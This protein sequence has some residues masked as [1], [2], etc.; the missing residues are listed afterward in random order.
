[1]SKIEGGLRT[2]N[3]FAKKTWIGKPLVSVITVV[4]NS[5]TL[6]EKTILSVLE[7][8][9]FNIEFIIIDG[10]SSDKTIEIIKKYNNQI[11]YWMS[12]KDSGLYD[13]MNKG[14]SYATG[15]YVWFI[16]SGDKIYADEVLETIF[17]I[18]GADADIYYGE[19]MMIGSTDEEIG[20]RRLSTPEELSWKSF[21]KGM[22]VSHQSII[23]RKSIAPL[24]E[25]QYRFSA[26]FDWVLKC[27]KKAKNV[28]NTKMVL[29]K[30]LDGGLT[31]KNIV[32]GLKERFRIM[33]KHYGYFSTFFNHL[34]L[35]WNFI[36]YVK[37]NKRF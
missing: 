26:D 8:T 15:E 14:L 4:Y 2:N 10:F 33:C 31:K 35:G 36:W 27:L 3:A 34:I 21:R 29:S 30:F 13:A 18:E 17:E 28:K 6:I 25:T 32:P 19:T 1:M 12:E 20:L 5:E 16:N 24:F 7:Q 23:V 11:A 22:L 9:Y 37:K